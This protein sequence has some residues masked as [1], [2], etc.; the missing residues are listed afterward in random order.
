MRHILPAILACAVLGAA[1]SATAARTAAA[2]LEG[3][4]TRVIDGDSLLLQAAAG[5]PPVEIRLLGIDA[6]EGCQDGGPQ[7]REALAE[8]V[9]DKTVTAA[10]KGR[11]HY[12]RTLATLTV[13]GL[14]V[15]QRMVAEGRA[16]SSRTKWNQ[17]P[18]VA[19]EKMAQALKRGLHATSGALMPAEFRRRHGPCQRPAGEAAAAPAP[20]VPNTLAAPVAPAAP[21]VHATAARLHCDGRTHCSQMTSCAEA[22]YFLQQC[23]GVKMDGDRDGVP[24]E[25]QWCR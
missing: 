23:P 11:D 25:R 5:A 7:A 21:A 18:F 17:G 4:V 22:T 10:T 15:N 8:Y 2:T 3:T 16:W 1:A 13:D 9:L 24:C 6:P 20:T 14:N 19:Q 12:G